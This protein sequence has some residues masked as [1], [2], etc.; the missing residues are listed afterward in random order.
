[1]PTVGIAPV[2][3]QQFFDVDGNPLA[4]GLLYTYASSTTTPLATFG[5][6]GGVSQNPNP[7]VLDSGGFASPGLFLQALAYTFALTDANNIPQWTQDGIVSEQAVAAVNN[8]SQTSFTSAGSFTFTVPTNVSGAKATV[9]GAGGAGGGSSTLN[10]GS[11]GGAG[12]ASYAYLSGLVPGN[13]IAVVVG[14]GGVGSSNATGGNGGGSSI[15]GTGIPTVTV[16]GGSGG[17]T[18][19][20][21]PGGGVGGAAGTGG[22]LNFGGNAGGFAAA[23]TVAAFGGPGAGSIFGGG[24]SGVFAAV[25]MAA[26]ASGAGGGGAGFGANRAGGNGADGLVLFEFLQ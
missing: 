26:I 21:V 1:M 24:A 6:A 23:S 12:G 25:G 22:D 2:A 19:A 3:L 18:G 4:G 8:P 14:A 20:G 9:L 5:D 13:A 16:N 10:N 17:A 7:L 15:S 11:G